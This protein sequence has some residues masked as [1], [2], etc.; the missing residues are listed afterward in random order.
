VSLSSDSSYASVLATVTV[1]AGATRA[2]FVVKTR[3]TKRMQVAT[4]AATYNDSR[5]T[6]MLAVTH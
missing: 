5:V 4:I 2:T 3:R 6:T 1:P